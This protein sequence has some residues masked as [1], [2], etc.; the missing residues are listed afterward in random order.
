MSRYLLLILFFVVL[1]APMALQRVVG[2]RSAASRADALTLVVVTP[3]Q[4]GIRREFATA[5]SRWHEK[6]FGRPV[7]VD[8]RSYGGGSDILRFFRSSDLLFQSQHTYQ[9]DI[10]WGGGDYL[11]DQQL[12]KEGYLQPLAID[13]AVLQA[14]FPK[15]QLA[16]M[17]LYDYTPSS[18]TRPAAAP[19]WYGAALSSFGIVYNR[20]LLR[21]LG[22]PE[23]KTW[24]DLADGRYAGWLVLA[25]PTR[26]ASARQVYV[27]IIE[28]QM[29]DAAARHES[30]DGAW[31]RGMGLIC[32]L[33]ANARLFT[34]SA[35]T[36]PTLV[37]SGEAA[38]GMAIDFYGRS[39]A[40][41]VG[42]NRMTYIEPIGA[43]IVNPDPIGVIKGAPHAQLAARFVEFVLSAEGQ[44]L[45]NTR[46]GA[47]GGPAQTSLRRLPIVPSVYEHS[48]DFTDKV[49]PYASSIGFV[50][51]N[52]RE[53]TQN[54]ISELIQMSCIDL[55]SELQETRR[56]ILSSPRAAELD[57]RLG[58]FPWD[59]QQ[60]LARMS[61]WN[62]KSP[63]ERMKLQRD[64][65]GEF[66]ERYRLLREE[67]QSR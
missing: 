26:S 14:A 16:G 50:K 2:T 41:A 52:Q 1:A 48:A 9:I 11:F 33:S 62:K 3:H 54:I 21:H 4:E 30:E 22:L 31:A 38:A 10:A 46:A 53:R 66:R 67:A 13:P 34:D 23:P 7:I 58:V 55:Q 12:K 35:S 39:Q 19:T 17:N 44:R 6:K 24:S 18:A 43:T 20:D 47:P 27:I 59:Q 40:D 15:P 36:V 28:K 8:Y 32:Q 42:E 37:G 64:W 60:A 61:E 29:I 51:S 56:A 65:T 5:F 63:A 57:A 49:N 45:W 25:D